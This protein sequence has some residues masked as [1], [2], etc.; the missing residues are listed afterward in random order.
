MRSLGELVSILL[1]FSRFLEVP[2]IQKENSFYTCFQPKRFAQ[3]KDRLIKNLF[4]S[5]FWW[6]KDLKIFIFGIEE[7]P[8][9]II[10]NGPPLPYADSWY[11]RV[12]RVD[13][14]IT[15][16]D[17]KLVP[18][19]VLH[20]YCFSIAVNR[21]VQIPLPTTNNILTHENCTP[22]I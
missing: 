21:P 14:T 10:F 17:T 11:Q 8:E 12:N 2:P 6:S 16:L 22:Q 15:I 13:I 4:W 18:D 3:I 19:F 7:H 9:S 1:R 20:A 5:Q